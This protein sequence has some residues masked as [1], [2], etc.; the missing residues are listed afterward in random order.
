[1]LQLLQSLNDGS[2]ELVDVPTP[3]LSEGFVR[4]RNMASVVSPG[5]ERQ[6]MALA[7]K[8][9]VGKARARPDLVR[10][11]LGKLQHDGLAA[12]YRAVTSKLACC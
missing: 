10:K 4:V 8:N 7:S 2:M 3:R 5:T 1:M 6:M 11:V 9:L 12:T